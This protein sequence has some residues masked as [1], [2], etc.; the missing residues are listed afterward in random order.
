MYVYIYIYIYTTLAISASRFRGW[1][2]LAMTFTGKFL[3]MAHHFILL[4]LN[5]I[6]FVLKGRDDGL[7]TVSWL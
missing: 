2:G 7:S 6:E 3:Y 1:V 4:W 5:P